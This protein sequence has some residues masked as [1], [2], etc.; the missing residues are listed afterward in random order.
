M[1]KMGSLQTSNRPKSLDEVIGQD[2]VVRRLRKTVADGRAHTFLFV[3]PS[4]VGKTTLARI[5]AN[6]FAKNMATQANIEEV[7]AAT[8]SGVDAMRAIANRSVFKAIGASPVK[9]IIVDEAQRLSPNSWDALLK[10]TEEPPKHVF[11]MFCSTNPSKIPKTIL[12]RCQKYEL[13]PV[14]EADLLKLLRRTVKN[15]KF[16]VEDDVLE[17]ISEGATGSPRQA[18]V[19]LEDC[20]YCENVAEAQRVMRSAAQAKETIDLCRFIITPRGGWPEAIKLIKGL[21]DIDPEG[22]RINIINYLAVALMGTKSDKQAKPLLYLIECFGDEYKNS[23]KMAPLLRS[24][25]LAMGMDQ[26]G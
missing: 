17:A 6:M 9:A 21:G 13:K 16:D 19:Y 1:T 8:N 3:G 10:A 25:G 5:I 14:S 18:L 12:T 15:E 2:D 11:W 26:D 4:G 20:L 22:I 24:M 7:D 23:D